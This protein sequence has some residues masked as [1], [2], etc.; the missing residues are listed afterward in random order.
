MTILE[1]NWIDE[2]LRLLHEMAL[3]F[4]QSEFE[5]HRE[6]WE[7]Q[8]KCDRSAWNAAGEAGLR[9]TSLL[10]RP[11]LIPES[12]LT[13]TSSTPTPRSCART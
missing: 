5:P 4:T 3:K 2:E 6:A 1:A 9:A 11:G 13:E 10:G 7:K 12:G 8:G